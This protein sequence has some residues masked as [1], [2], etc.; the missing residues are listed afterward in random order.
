MASENVCRFWFGLVFFEKTKTCTE[1]LNDSSRPLSRTLLHFIFADSKGDNRRNCH[2][3]A[4]GSTGTHNLPEQSCAWTGV[5][6]SISFQKTCTAVVAQAET[7]ESNGV[8]QG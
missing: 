6:I 1:L 5:S 8:T 4:Q 3:K 2:Q 7:T